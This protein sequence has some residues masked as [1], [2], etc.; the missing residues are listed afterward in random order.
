ME[1]GLGVLVRVFGSLIR[2][3]GLHVLANDDDRQEHQLQKC[4]RD[5]PHDDEL[6]VGLQRRGQRDQRHHREKVGTPHGA[7]S[8]RDKHPEAG[9][10]P[11]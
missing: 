6:L 1:D 11:T 2:G 3:C 8:H 7:D 10:Q 5:P 4:L 9:V